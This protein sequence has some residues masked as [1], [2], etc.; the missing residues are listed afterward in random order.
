MY[1]YTVCVTQSQFPT[2]QDVAAHRRHV[3]LVYQ[4]SDWHVPASC[5]AFTSVA[6]PFS[7]Q[8][9]DVDAWICFL[10][11]DDCIVRSTGT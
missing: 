1:V 11:H 9:F 5:S 3:A 7:C 2:L 8:V 10:H 6:A 4:I